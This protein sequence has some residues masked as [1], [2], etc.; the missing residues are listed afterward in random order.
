MLSRPLMAH[1]CWGK[2]PATYHRYGRL[3]PNQIGT[4]Y[5]SHVAFHMVGFPLKYAGHQK[6]WIQK[7]TTIVD[8]VLK[9]LTQPNEM[10]TLSITFIPNPTWLP[11]RLGLACLLPAALWTNRSIWGSLNSCVLTLLRSGCSDLLWR[12]TLSCFGCYTFGFATAFRFGSLC[13]LARVSI[14]LVVLVLTLILLAG[15]AR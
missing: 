6:W 13:P 11:Y 4:F 2:P 10:K 3:N 1:M 12:C 15:A 9:T 14:L 5:T 7:Y 8:F